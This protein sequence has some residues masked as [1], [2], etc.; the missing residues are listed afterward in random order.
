MELFFSTVEIFLSSFR[1]GLCSLLLN[2][3]KICM[4]IALFVRLTRFLINFINKEIEINF[5]FR[6]YVSKDL[7]ILILK[8]ENN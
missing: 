1:F 4:V 6:R 3:M 8:V 5:Q 7:V 2:R